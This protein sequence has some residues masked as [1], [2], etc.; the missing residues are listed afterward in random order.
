LVVHMKGFNEGV[1]G[2][3][4]DDAVEWLGREFGE[5]RAAAAALVSREQEVLG[6][7]ERLR[8]ERLRERAGQ[9]RGVWRAPGIEDGFG[10]PRDESKERDDGF[11]FDR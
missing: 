11:S 2:F 1:E 10:Q 8:E 3:S 5:R 6:T 7:F 4:K 9:E